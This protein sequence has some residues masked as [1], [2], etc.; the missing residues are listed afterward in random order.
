M[1]MI[2]PW[3]Q[4]CSDGASLYQCATGQPRDVSISRKVRMLNAGFYFKH[5]P[6]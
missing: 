3:D 6:I 5:P 4:Y 2:G 1:P